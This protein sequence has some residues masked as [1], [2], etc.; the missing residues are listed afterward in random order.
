MIV[1]IMITKKKIALL[2]SVSLFCLTVFCIPVFAQEVP[3]P[4]V[5]PGTNLNPDVTSVVTELTSLNKLPNQTPQAVVG[6]I[7][8]F[9]LGFLGSIALC[10]FIYAGLLWMTTAGGS[11]KQGK[12]LKIML[13]TSLGIMLLFSSYAVVNF[14]FEAFL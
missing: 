8:K 2:L 6:S 3:V 4:D 7:I 5:E 13:W 14:V 11:E 12:A 9:M 1:N 10:M